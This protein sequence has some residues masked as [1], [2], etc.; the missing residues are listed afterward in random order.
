MRICAATIV[1]KLPGFSVPRRRDNK[2]NS[3][4]AYFQV[5][6]N[7]FHRRLPH[8]V[9]Q[10]DSPVSA[11]RQ[12]QISRGS[13]LLPQA[14][15]RTPS[16]ARTYRCRSG[17]P[18]PTATCLLARLPSLGPRKCACA[19]QGKSRFRAWL[20]AKPGDGKVWVEPEAG[21]T[22]PRLMPT[23]TSMRLS[24]NGALLS[25]MARGI[26]TAERILRVSRPDTPHDGL[27]IPQSWG[28]F[29]LG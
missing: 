25:A 22:S 6:K 14:D 11:L 18:V 12:K 21:V 8:N 28:R 13:L 24:A 19:G 2:W 17:L 16:S 5:F 9:A 26:S 27:S 7:V 3:R 1:S 29:F 10:G 20:V 15:K 23:R 4:C